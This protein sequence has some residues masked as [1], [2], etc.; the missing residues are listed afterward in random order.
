V[1]DFDRAAFEQM[2][3]G[4]LRRKRKDESVSD[5]ALAEALARLADFTHEEEGDG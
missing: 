2:A 4:E 5:T 1:G 3:L